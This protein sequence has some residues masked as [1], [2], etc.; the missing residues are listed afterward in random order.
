M[1]VRHQCADHFA[2]PACFSLLFFPY[3]GWMDLRAREWGAIVFTP[4]PP[5]VI[6]QE[7]GVY[8]SNKEATGAGWRNWQRLCELDDGERGIERMKDLYNKNKKRERD[9]NKKIG[10]KRI[11]SCHGRRPNAPRYLW[12]MDFLVDERVS[13]GSSEAHSISFYFFS[14]ITSRASR[15]R[16]NHFDSISFRCWI[17]LAPHIHLARLMHRVTYISIRFHPV[18]NC[19]TGIRFSWFGARRRKRI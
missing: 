8:S 17:L 6:H 4:R 12:S 3:L 1:Y 14:L 11:G 2:P 19:Y 15:E 13:K 10:K 7:S 18:Q 16:V 5:T 9:G